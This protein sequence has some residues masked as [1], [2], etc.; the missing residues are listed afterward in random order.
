MNLCNKIKVGI[1]LG[2]MALPVFKQ[3]APRSRNVIFNFFPFDMVFLKKSNWMKNKNYI[4]L[5]NIQNFII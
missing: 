1:D 4:Y 3:E 5:T 2:I